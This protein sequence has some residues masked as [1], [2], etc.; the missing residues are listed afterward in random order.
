MGGDYLFFSSGGSGKL[1]RPEI[2]EHGIPP[3]VTWYSIPDHVILPY[4]CVKYKNL[5][6]RYRLNLYTIGNI[7]T[8]LVHV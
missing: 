3:G 4:L 5:A 6:N 7:Y 1:S 2:S 8:P